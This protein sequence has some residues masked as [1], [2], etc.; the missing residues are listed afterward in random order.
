MARRYENK[1]LLVCDW[2][3]GTLD[4]TLCRLT[5]GMAVQV[6]NDGTDEVGGD[7]FDDVVLRHVVQKV[8]DSRRID[9]AG[10]RQPNAS[11]RLLERCERAKIALSSQ[12]SVQI[13]SPNFFRGLEESEIDCTLDQDELE[14]VVRPLL[15]KGFRRITGVLENAGFSPEQVALCIAT[16]GMSSM[17]AVGRRLRE[18]FGPAQVEIPDN[19]A[20]LV[21]EGAAWIATDEK[22]LH[23]AKNI[24]LLLARNSHLTLVKAGTAMPRNGEVQKMQFHLYCTDPRDGTAKFEFR[25][26]KHAGKD[27]LREEPRTTLGIAT[28]AVDSKAQPF[29]ER[30]ELDVRIDDNLI[31][32]AHARSLMA[33]DQERQEIHD[34]EFGLA[35]PTETPTETPEKPPERMSATST[36]RGALT[37]RANVSNTKDASLVPGELLHECEPHPFGDTIHHFSEEQKHERLYYEPCTGCGR[38]SN[39]PLCEC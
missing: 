32:S 24:E 39:D 21:A 1:L 13:Y 30:L 20:T 8:S 2:G 25:S 15:D 18:L 11:Q 7:V 33:R 10:D 22:K 16:G 3:G 37:T 26:P 9:D 38:A 35:L 23:L 28:I 14:S 12:T 19:T 17:P 6:A 36:S 5:E 29:R 27:I 31:L 4:L 34:L